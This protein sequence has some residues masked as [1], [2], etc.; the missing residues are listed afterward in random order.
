[1]ARSQEL[2]GRVWLSIPGAEPGD[3]QAGQIRPGP[4]PAP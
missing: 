4:L 1:M 3:P 2:L